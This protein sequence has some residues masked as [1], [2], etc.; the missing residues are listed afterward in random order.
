V[1]RWASAPEGEAELLDRLIAGR[2]LEREVDLGLQ[3]VV[4]QGLADR[5]RVL[6]RELQRDRGRLASTE[7]RVSDSTDVTP[8]IPLV[9]QVSAPFQW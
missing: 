4:L 3:L 6:S 8:P 7:A 9:L 5:R 2:V 1:R